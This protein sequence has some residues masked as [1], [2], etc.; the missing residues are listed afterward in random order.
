VPKAGVRIAAELS[1]QPPGPVSKTEYAPAS[2]VWTFVSVSMDPVTPGMTAPLKRQSRCC[3]H[4]VLA[5]R[6]RQ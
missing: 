5:A 3:L 2:E 6:S 4:D 1:V